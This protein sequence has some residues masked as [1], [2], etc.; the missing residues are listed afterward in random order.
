MTRLLAYL[1]F[2]GLTVGVGLN[3]KS[4]AEFTV[5][6]LNEATAARCATVNSVLP[7]TCT[8]R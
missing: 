4:A 6:E 7:D 5:A 8:L 3:V 1:L 2:A